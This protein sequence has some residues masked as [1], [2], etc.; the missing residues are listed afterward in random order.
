MKFTYA[1]LFLFFIGCAISK[2]E[3]ELQMQGV[4]K[5]VSLSIKTDKTDSSFSNTDQLKIYTS[6]YMMYAKV[7]SPDSVSRFG[8]G[9]YGLVKDSI[10]ENIIYSANDTVINEKPS[11][12]NLDIKKTEKGYQQFITGMPNNAGEKM[13]LTELYASIGLTQT[14]PLDGAW[15]LVKRYEIKGKDTS[16]NKATEYKVYYAGY[17][18]WGTTWKD[19]INKTHTSIGYGKFTMSSKHKIKE[20]MLVST[21]AQV[22]GHDFDIDIELIGKDGFTQRMVEK[23]GSIAVE[24][25][26]RLK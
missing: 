23:D 17:C 6:N 21:Y 24:I 10:L 14:T 7:N 4:Y 19:S 9:S 5:M 20:S 22:R 11:S 25:F 16:F 18:M 3:T 26:E 12:Y 1:A 13:D 2:N 8:I 15:K